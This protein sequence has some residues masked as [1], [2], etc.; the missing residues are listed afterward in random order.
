M[1]FCRIKLFTSEQ[2]TL[3]LTYEV[4]QIMKLKM[5]RCDLSIVAK[6]FNAKCRYMSGEFAWILGISLSYY[7]LGL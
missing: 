5:Q 6:R 1:A 2:I 4:S 7:K 3:L